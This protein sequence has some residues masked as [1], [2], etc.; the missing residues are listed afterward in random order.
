MQAEFLQTHAEM[1][2]LTRRVNKQLILLETVWEGVINQSG[3]GPQR[4]E[5]GV[6]RE[7]QINKPPHFPP[8]SGTEPMPKDECAIETLLF[9]V[10]GAREDISDHAVRSALITCLR[11]G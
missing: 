6:N 5:R 9:Q 2:E 7:G 4:R 10:R 11:G 3:P 1:I 8:F